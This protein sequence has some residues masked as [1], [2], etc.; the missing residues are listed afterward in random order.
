MNKYI[1]LVVLLALATVAACA[2]AA[3]AAPPAAVQT[4]ANKTLVRQYYDQILN[5]GKF[6]AMGDYVSP[7]YKRYLS[8]LAA[9]INAD[10]QKQR[11][12]GLRAAFPDLKLTIDDIIAEGDRVA[13][14][15][16]VTATQKGAFSGI[17]P[18]GKQA[19]VTALETL[20]IENGKIV[21]HWG[22]SDNLDMMQQLGAIPAAPPA[23]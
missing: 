15:G 3:P 4:E 17:P 19:T 14:R 22:G 2:Q 8:A 7:N 21:E 1:L 12:A 6:D 11:L 5:A 13:I 23:K 10:A 16:T 9:P 18:T 20:R